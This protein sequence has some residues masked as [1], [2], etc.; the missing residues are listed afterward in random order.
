MKR[1]YRKIFGREYESED[2]STS[3]RQGAIQN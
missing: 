3:E 2:T 1:F